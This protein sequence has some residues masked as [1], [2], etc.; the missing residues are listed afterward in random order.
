MAIES[1]KRECGA[2]SYGAKT[3]VLIR[4][5]LTDDIANPV[6]SGRDHEI[7]VDSLDIVQQES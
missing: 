4:I 7:R 3:D 1:D 6:R 2:A 5:V